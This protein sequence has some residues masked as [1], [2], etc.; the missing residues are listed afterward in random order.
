M[1][2]FNHTVKCPKCGDRAY[3]N[4]LDK[5]IYCMYPHIRSCTGELMTCGYFFGM[6][7]NEGIL[8]RADY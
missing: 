2:Q 4:D 3:Q 1:L 8:P 6:E 7:R 5:S